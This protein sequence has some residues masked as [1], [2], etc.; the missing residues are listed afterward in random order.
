MG[1]DDIWAASD[2]APTAV[3][4]APAAEVVATRVAGAIPPGS[5]V[6]DIGAGHGALTAELLGRGLRVTAVEPV[7][8]MLAVG[9]S[10]VP[11]ASWLAA[12]GEATGLPD[13]CAAAVASS[14]GSM[15]CDPAAGP[16]EWARILQPKGTL[17]MTAWDDRG[18]LAEMT[19]RMFAVMHPGKESPA[20]MGWG[21]DE[22]ARSL[23]SH[24]F[25]EVEVSHHE[26]PWNFDSVADG[27]RLYLQG[28]PAHTFSLRQAG[29]RRDEL[30]ATLEAHLR[31]HEVAGRVK[32]T[33]GYALVVARR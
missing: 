22:H 14:F 32:S 10:A 7:G 26:L 2:Y 27:M 31:E 5:A 9:R 15:F 11:G 3:R 12:T 28:S 18:F 30:L 19:E 24:D 1:L 33:A 21:D 17:V 6:V 20:H 25:S 8:R 16:R 29:E 23:L 13:S 4:L